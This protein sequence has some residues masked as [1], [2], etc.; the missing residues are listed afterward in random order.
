MKRWISLLA[1]LLCAVLLLAGCNSS[2]PVDNGGV[3]DPPPVDTDTDIGGE[4]VPDPAS[5][6]IMVG[7]EAITGYEYQFHYTTAVNEF[8]SVN[9]SYLDGYLDPT[10]PFGEQPYPG[11][12]DLTWEDFFR[13]SVVS[14]LVRYVALYQEAVEQDYTLSMEDELG[15]ESNMSNMRAYCEESGVVPEE[16]LSQMY[17]VGM[18]E[19]LL[20]NIMTRFALA[21]SFEDSIVR[22]YSFTDDEIR[23]YYEANKEEGADYEGNV[24][25][26]RYILLAEKEEAD[27][28]YQMFQDSDGSEDAFA[29]LAIQY[30]LDQQTAASGG[31][32][33]DVGPNSA[34]ADYDDFDSWCFDAARQPGDHALI[35]AEE[36]FHLLYFCESGEPQWKVMGRSAMEQEKL[37]EYRLTLEEKYPVSFVTA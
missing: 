21:V 1:L 10:Q 3:S 24:V 36:Q 8:L 13:D 15:I 9:G 29:A 27:S 19:S 17:G 11:S 30:S 32:C 18:T 25:T 7:D 37:S 5:P 6:I 14:N 34:P 20:Q 31:L 35:E 12:E 28:V 22:T 33:E 26:V 2:P 16:F 23:A 4:E